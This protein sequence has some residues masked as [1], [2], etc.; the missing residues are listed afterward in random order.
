MRYSQSKNIVITDEIKDEYMEKYYECQTCKYEPHLLTILG[1]MFRTLL[2]I[3]Y[4]KCP[5]CGCYTIFKVK[6]IK[7]VSAF[8]KEDKNKKCGNWSREEMVTA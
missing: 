8:L 4:Y 2:P 7:N 3:G 1:F 5:K 6:R